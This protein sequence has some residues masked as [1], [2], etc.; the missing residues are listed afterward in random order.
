MNAQCTCDPRSSGQSIYCPVHGALPSEERPMPEQVKPEA[1][2]REWWDWDM[3]LGICNRTGVGTLGETDRQAIR[4]LKTSY[5]TLQAQLEQSRAE[6]VQL[7][8]DL[9]AS[10]FGAGQAVRARDMLEDRNQTLEQ[11][12]KH[13]VD[14]IEAQYADK[15]ATLE[16][17][18]AKEKGYNEN[19]R[20]A[21]ENEARI[22]LA[23]LKE[24]AKAKEA[25]GDEVSANAESWNTKELECLDLKNANARL[26]TQLKAMR[27]ALEFYANKNNWTDRWVE[28]SDDNCGDV[29]DV[30]DLSDVDI[31]KCNEEQGG[32]YLTYG[33]KRARK[34]LEETAGD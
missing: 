11:T 3:I 32:T 10:Q 19:L 5:E 14:K 7:K 29:F 31:E 13:D 25:Y 18:F 21:L 26:C 2:A 27:E 1:Q 8:S 6:V 4:A 24:L 15:V 33:G 16:K 28:Y 34:L 20:N 22:H 12:L 30:I 17:E 9:S 23:D